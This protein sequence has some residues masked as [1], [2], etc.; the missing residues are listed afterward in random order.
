MPENGKDWAFEEKRFVLCEGPHDKEVL[1]FLIAERKLGAFQIKTSHECV[2]SAGIDG[3]GPALQGFPA[4]RGFKSLDGIAIVVDNDNT[5]R[6]PNIRRQLQRY[7]YVP[8][9]PNYGGRIRDK[10]VIIVPIPDHNECGDLEKLCLPALYSAWPGAEECVM[11]YLEWTGA[12]EWK[13]QNQLWKAKVRCVIS[14]HYEDDPYKGLGYLF[15][16][17]KFRHLAR[18]RCFDRLVYILRNFDQAVNDPESN[19][20]DFHFS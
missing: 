7:G 16:D 3:F 18:H 9:T 17:K 2:G 19:M 4:I 20:P 5:R 10:S 11:T 14:G 6:L 12:L 13:K 1:E 15:K 8:T